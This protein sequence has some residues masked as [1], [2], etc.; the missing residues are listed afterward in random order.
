MKWRKAILFTLLAVV[1]GW[2][3]HSAQA[4]SPRI[5]ALVYPPG[6]H[7]GYRPVLTNAQLD[8]MWG[9]VCEGRYVPNFHSRTQ[10]ELHRLS[11]WGQFAGIQ[12]GGRTTMAFELFVTRYDSVPDETGTAWS[13]RAFLDLQTALHAQGYLLDRPDADLLPAGR[14]GGALVA[15]QYLGKQ[16]LVVMASWSGTLEVEGIALYDHR[17]PAGRQTAWASLV[18]QIHLA[19]NRGF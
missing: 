17:P 10:D 13:E 7:V 1:A 8:C 15:V 14:P 9:F 3:P 11:G 12:H 19:S 18:L 2:V 5:P 4:A 16:D 6:A